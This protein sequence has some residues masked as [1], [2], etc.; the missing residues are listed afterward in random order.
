MM[1]PRERIEYS[2]IVDRPRLSLPN[3]ARLAV[4]TIVNVEEWEIARPMARQVLPAPGGAN[5]IPDVPN[6][7]WH[8][9]GMRVGFWRLQAALDRFGVTPTLSINAA[10]CSS[11]PRVAGAARDAGWEFM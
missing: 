2:A 7:T 11:H 5:P 3:G 4:W 6:W 1:L 9:Y 10:V 8:E